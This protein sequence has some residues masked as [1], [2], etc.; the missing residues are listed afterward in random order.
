MVIRI[1]DIDKQKLR[2]SG[3]IK[4]LLTVHLWTGSV[5]SA[6]NLRKSPEV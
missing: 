4:A 3:R 1:I 2:P 5:P 6:L